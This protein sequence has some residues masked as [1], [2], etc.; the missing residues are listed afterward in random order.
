[1]GE[2]EAPIAS[3]VVPNYNHGR[4]LRQRIDSIRAQSFQDF[5]VL[6]LDDCSTDDSPIIL[7]GYAFDPRVRLEFNDANSGSTFKQWNK[8]VRMAR[9]KYVWIAESD[10][11]A[12]PRLLER[13]VSILDSDSSIAF[14]YCRSWRVTDGDHLD[15]FVHLHADHLG[16]RWDKDYCADGHDECRNY[17][18]RFNVVPNASAAVFRRSIYE[19]VGGADETFRL[20]GDW[21]L[22][23]AMALT[24]KVAYVSEPLNYQRFHSATVQSNTSPASMAIEDL[25][26]LGWILNRVAP[27]KEVLEDALRWQATWW[28][29]AVLS[30]H[31]PWSVK[32]EILR[33]VRALDPRP[34]RRAMRPA[35][36]AVQRKILRHYR[37]LTNGPGSLPLSRYLRRKPSDLT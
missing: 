13:L 23:A 26:V 2:T 37:S 11:Y 32:I 36:A 14:A 29:P 22:W 9:G 28:V 16:P 17:F 7:R 5:E 4:F 3:V 21:K 24:G 30:M 8:G 27:G 19:M 10:D 35:L 6:L 33:R 25:D 1:M 12:D 18:T 20:S 34:L 31:V 15:G